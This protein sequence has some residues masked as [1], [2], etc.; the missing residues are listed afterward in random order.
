MVGSRS[1]RMMPIKM[2]LGG[3]AVN[4]IPDIIQHGVNGWLCEP[5]DPDDLAS[6]VLLALEDEVSSEVVAQAVATASRNEWSQVAEEYAA[7]FRRV[8]GGDTR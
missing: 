4:G 7:T 5:K 1:V 8:L 3:S 6:K 2:N